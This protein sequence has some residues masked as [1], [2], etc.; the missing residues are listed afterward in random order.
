MAH[1]WRKSWLIILV[2]AAA[3]LWTSAASNAIESR[4]ILGT[5]CSATA[6]IKFAPDAMTVRLFSSQQIHVYKV[7]GYD[8]SPDTVKVTWTDFKKEEVWAE[9]SEFSPNRRRMYLQKHKVAPR[10]EYNRC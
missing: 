10:R 5:W 7:V 8:Y 4:D 3:S 6:K 2:V 1:A 9:Y